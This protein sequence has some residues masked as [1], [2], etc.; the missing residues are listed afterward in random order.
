MNKEH[1]LE[2]QYKS[3]CDQFNSGNFQCENENTCCECGKILKVIF[4]DWQSI[5]IEFATNKETGKYR[6]QRAVDCYNEPAKTI[7]FELKTGNVLVS[8]WFKIKE[9]ND[10]VHNKDDGKG[11]F[12]FKHDSKKGRRELVNHLLQFGVISIPSGTHVVV[13]NKEDEL[14][15]GEI[16]NYYNEKEVKNRKDLSGSLRAT[17]LI[18]KETL[19]ELIA[20]NNGLKKAQELVEKYLKESPRDV[21]QYKVSPGTYCINFSDYYKNDIVIKKEDKEKNLRTFLHLK[22]VELTKKLKM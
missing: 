1:S 8:D 17:T 21:L 12:S 10:I 7:N 16:I 22:K 5:F 18:E 15:I 20:K 14:N 11:I 4:K 2:E 6:W 19:I 9:F 13:V 3:L